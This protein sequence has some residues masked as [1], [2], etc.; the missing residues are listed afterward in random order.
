METETTRPTFSFDESAYYPS[1][2]P[3]VGSD[4]PTIMYGPPS[5]PPAPPAPDPGRRPGR[6]AIAL[7][8]ASAALAGGVGGVFAGRELADDGV[9]AAAAPAA[10]QPLGS[11][12]APVNV[13][14]AA[15]GSYQAVA[16]K[17]LPSVVHLNV[18]GY[19]G[20]GTGSGVVIRADGYVLTN[21]HVVDGAQTIRV[22]FNDG[23]AEDGRVVGT[24]PAS[25][26]AV[27]KV[28]KAGL[29]AA[30]LG[31][32]S[33]VKVG[34]QVLAVGSPLGLSGTVTAG[35]VSA[36]NRPVNTTDRGGS[37]VS[38]VIDAI[39]T[40]A[41]INPGNS[42]GALVDLAGQVIGIN[43]AIASTSGGNIGVGFAIPIDQ[44]KVIAQQLIQNGR[45]SRAQLGVSIATAT[46]SAG[47]T[48]AVLTSV[49]PG[50]P[51][52]QA[53][54]RAGDAIVRLGDT[55]VADADALVAAIRS[56]R[57]GETVQVTYER[58]GSRKTVSV[59]LTDATTG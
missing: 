13:S 14:Q 10:N 49:T 1:E 33:N 11:G 4:E 18:A 47:D 42:G 9:P 40:D 3:Y 52:E 31:V 53:G 51:A 12:S 59:R 2:P 25:D 39:Q 45:A 43:S 15:P 36:L 50:G 54:L 27:V 41:A 6:L 44:A 58:D 57:P 24:D 38:T 46:T 34:D 37:G 26:L 28:D 56:H 8:A 48:R 7:V 55:N 29:V 22:T 30:T 21:N 19:G 23:S 17:V 16:A 35:I 5:A 32:S 20:R